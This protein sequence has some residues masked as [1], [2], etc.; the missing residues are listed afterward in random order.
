[1]RNKI[2][3]L[4]LLVALAVL[5]CPSAEAGI[6]RKFYKAGKLIVGTPLVATFCV[7]NHSLKFAEITAKAT[8]DETVE[9]VYYTV[10]R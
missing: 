10:G 7:V 9:F 4:Y 8:I 1:M 6:L 5:A 2:V 3:H